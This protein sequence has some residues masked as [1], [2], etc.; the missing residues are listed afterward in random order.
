[1]SAPHEL[2]PASEVASDSPRLAWLKRHG[3]ELFDGDPDLVGTES[4]ETGEEYQAW[5]CLPIG[6]YELRKYSCGDTADEACANYAKA[7]GL[8]LWNESP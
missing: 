1:M 3:L 5:Y 4:P 2:F 6:S 7:H 8:K